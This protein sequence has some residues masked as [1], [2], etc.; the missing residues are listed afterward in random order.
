MQSSINGFANGFTHV[1]TT[2]IEKWNTP[3]PQ[4]LT[5]C[6]PGC[7]VPPWSQWRMK[8]SCLDAI[9]FMGSPPQGATEDPS[10][11][12][13]T[14]QQLWADRFRIQVPTGHL[15]VRWCWP[16]HGGK[17]LFAS[18]QKSW[19]PLSRGPVQGSH[20]SSVQKPIKCPVIPEGTCMTTKDKWQPR[21]LV[22]PR[23]T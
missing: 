15:M 17:A 16:R 3:A 7:L 18:C 11:L 21:C 13:S 22:W 23:D 6:F 20:S 19:S 12:R 14:A 2:Q 1:I 4:R 5:Y 10:S 9:G 8:P